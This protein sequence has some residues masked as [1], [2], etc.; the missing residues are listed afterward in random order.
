VVQQAHAGNVDTVFIAGKARKWRGKLV[1]VNL[2]KHRDMV[3]ESRQ[4]LFDQ[5]GFNLNIFG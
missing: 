3:L 4:Y 2:K 1:D 5:R